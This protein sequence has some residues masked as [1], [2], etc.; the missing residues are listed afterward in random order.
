M[1]LVERKAFPRHKVCGGCLSA[2]TVERLRSLGLGAELGRLG[3][4]SL[5]R[6]KLG[7][8]G[9][10]VT[11]TLPGGVSV[12]RRA[13]DAALVEAA[14]AAGAEFR[15]PCQGV[16]GGVDDASRAVTLRSAGGDQQVSAGLVIDASGLGE[17]AVPARRLGAGA[18]RRIGCSAIVDGSVDTYRAGTIHM[19][20]GRAGYAGLVRLEDGRLNVAA[21]LDPSS[22]RRLGVGGSVEH[23]IETAGFAA[24]PGLGSATW[25][26]TPPMMQAPRWR[27]QE[28]LFVVGDA[29][30]YVEP[31][32]GEGIGWAVH[33]AVLLT[34][35]ALAA[36]RRWSGSLAVDWAA[37]YRAELARAQ[38]DCRGLAWALRHP[39]AARSALRLIE[40]MPAL[41]SPLV[42]R[43]QGPT[44]AAARGV[45]R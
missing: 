35:L 22:M 25:S 29:A 37:L 13:L 30:G 11:L 26:G 12:S 23:V 43:L 36:R 45:G 14:I 16:I 5:R 18:S 33:S 21:A 28:R 31:F 15:A 41:G 24:V 4:V 6:L 27:A 17:A 34:P 42:R 19:A 38:R 32:T 44:L 2:R 10:D 20:V 39:L 9:R 1:L 40:R 3:G 8:W 7:G